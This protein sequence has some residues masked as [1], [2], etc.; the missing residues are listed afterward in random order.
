[1]SNSKRINIEENWD[2]YF[3]YIGEEPCVI[4]LN[5][6]LHNVAPFAGYGYRMRITAQMHEVDENGFPTASESEILN[7]IEDTIEQ[8]L[9]A[10][11]DIFGGVSKCAS[12][13]RWYFFPKNNDRSKA[14]VDE[15]MLAFKDYEY[16]IDILEDPEWGAYFDY[17]YPSIYDLKSMNNRKLV[18][19]FEENGDLLERER[20]VDHWLYF[21][22]EKHAKKCMKE[23]EADGWTQ[24][25]LQK[26]ESGEYQLQIFK[27]HNIELHEVDQIT[28]NLISTAEE[29]EGEYDGWEAFLVK[30]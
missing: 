15:V 28:W 6:A 25:D 2:A 29:H 3:T 26:T 27:S 30:E 5:M 19:T 1:M 21:E 8:R 14:V 4:R 23:F 16:D 12:G 17:L 13:V 7:K 24:E 20:R 10:E 11:G 9:K 18:D 22:T